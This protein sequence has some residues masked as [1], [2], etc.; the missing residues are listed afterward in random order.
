MFAEHQYLAIVRSPDSIRWKI[1]IDRKTQEIKQREEQLSKTFQGSRE[2]KDLTQAHLQAKNLLSQ[3]RTYFEQESGA[4]NA[5]LEQAIDMYSRCLATSDDFDDDGH[6]RLCSLWFS[7][8]HDLPLQAKVRI[9]LD[10]IPSR[11]FIFLAHQLSARLSASSGQVEQNQANLHGIVSR[12]CQEHPFH[13][14][15]QVFA[16]RTDPVQSISAPNRRQS[17]RH[18][19]SPSQTDR[20]SAADD[21]FS[22]L[23]GDSNAGSR[24]RD[25]EQVCIASLQWATFQI[26]GN[27]RYAKN[28]KGPFKVP[29]NLDLLKIKNLQVPVVTAK[30]PVDLT[31]R[32]DRCVW[33]K[34]FEDKFVT[35][36]GV[37]LP[38]ISVCIGEDNSKHKQ[39]VGGEAIIIHIL[40][41]IIF[42]S[43]KAKEMMTCVKMRSWNKSLG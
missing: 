15:Y 8:F 33:I 5:F 14:L 20:S 31:M 38:K 11:K 18:D 1:Y 30:T 27:A 13:S 26:K 34:G 19:V 37:N 36:G 22:R 28:M 23:R 6:L 16:L 42:H 32:Y 12:M 21:L 7:N 43:S 3:D 35:A 9:A 40:S 2:F 25:V 41:L 17:S 39:L 4:R 29:D 24:V 10:R